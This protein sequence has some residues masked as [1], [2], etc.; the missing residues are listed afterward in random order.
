[1]PDSI[2]RAVD[3]LK[4]GGLVGMP[5]ET[6][7][8]LAADANNVSAINKIFS[9][10][11]RPT[12]HPLIVHIAQA[13]PSDANHQQVSAIAWREI[14]SQ[15]SRD[16]SPEALMLAHKFWP[17]PLTMILPKAKN[18]LLEVTGGQETIGIR[19]PQ[20]PIAQQLLKKFGG[21]L[22]A[23]SANRFGRISPT[24]AEHVREEF[25]DNEVLVLDGG[26]C[27]VGIESTIVDLTRLD[28]HGAVILRPGAITQAMIDQALDADSK[29]NKARV[30]AL[31]TVPQENKQAP[32]VSGSLSAH[33]APRTKLVVYDPKDLE[34][35]FSKLNNNSDL[36]RVAW[37]HFPGDL[38]IN[39]FGL[40]NVA[41]ELLLPFESKALARE[42]Y[43]M[44]RK[45][46]VQN[47][48]CIFFEQLPDG[49]EWDA[50]RDRLGRASVGS[51][52]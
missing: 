25:P 36:K 37:V 52:L 22:A 2:K 51:G 30:N 11:G 21:G 31:T 8:G 6:V 5:T 7:Y 3:V 27:D 33:Y 40:K 39:E 16:V 50:I 49:I 10:K 19:C 14:L 12:G 48:D 41:K 35:L 43:A 34:A 23:P 18:V 46:D 17:G 29:T 38:S 42:L 24:T 32:R 13:E 9:S 26:A 47:L 28:T 4:A 45:L 20:H 15:W 1:M 44:L